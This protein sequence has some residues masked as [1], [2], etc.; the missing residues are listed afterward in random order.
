MDHNVYASRRARLSQAIQSAGGG[1][2]ICPTALERVRSRDTHYPY[3][4]DSQFFYLTGFTEPEAWLVLRADGRSVLFLRPKDEER[5]IWDG[6][7]LGPDA[8]PASLGVDE[9]WPVTALDEK[10]PE[11]LADQP[12]V[13][14]PLDD[15][16]EANQ[17][18]SRAL[19]TLRARER[20][21]VRAPGAFRDLHVLLDEM[22]LTK[23]AHE[24]HEMQRAAD[25]AAAAHV[26]AMRTCRPGL[27]EYHL[28]AEILHSFRAQGASG[29]AYNSI[30]AAGANACVLHYAAGDTVL[31]EG[32]L[33]L[34]D[35]GAEF[36]SYASD[37]TRTFPVGGR[38][39]E[40]QRDLYDL[41]V[42][43]QQAAVDATRPGMR[44]I[45]GHWAAVRVLSQGM[46]DL[47]LLD[48]SKCG[49]VDDVVA[50]AA[51]RRFYMHGTGHWLGMDVHDVGDV[52]SRD[53]APVDQ[54]DG[55]GGRVV[56]HPSR[57]LQPGMVLTIEPG[58]YVR[59]SEGV[60]ERYWNIGIRIE[61][62]AVITANGCKLI[63]RGVPVA[64][65]A[66]EAL[67]AEG[68]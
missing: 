29:P 25:I 1:V 24:L 21:G 12:A 52:L 42:A 54:P 3:R 48:K 64:A 17:H 63:S 55:M 66:I 10:L 57:V 37:I 20:S 9:A 34:I 50:N 28:E 59:P 45:D 31:K 40:P 7:R 44:K 61:D 62:D 30:V 51:Y 43:A 19:S 58:I 60:P 38:F 8:A 39:S 13:W 6:Y 68:R 11:L 56:K 41:V 23:D 18:L 16:G 65:G 14:C 26:R 46:L 2:V 47:G 27:R 49:S 33:C 67:M 5:E 22:R 4:H 36:G 35:A 53:E 32:E 15:T